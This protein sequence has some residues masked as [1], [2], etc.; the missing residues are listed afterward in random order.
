MWKK[1]NWKQLTMAVTLT[2]S[3]FYMQH[4]FAAEKTLHD[5]LPL[6]A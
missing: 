2:V 1:G 4:S 6:I 5:F 3:F